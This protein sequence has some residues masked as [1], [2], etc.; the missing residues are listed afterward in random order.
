MIDQGPPSNQLKPKLFPNW[1]YGSY[2]GTRQPIPL[3]LTVE[4]DAN[5][6]SP[7]PKCERLI[8]R[9]LLGHQKK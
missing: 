9:S 2:F 7:K 6:Y 3:C 1:L 5:Q 4:H 8:P